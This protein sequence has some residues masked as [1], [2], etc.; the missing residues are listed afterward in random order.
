MKASILFFFLVLF[1]FACAQ[2]HPRI[3]VT[4][5]AELPQWE[6]GVLTIRDK[7]GKLYTAIVKNGK[8]SITISRAFSEE[9]SVDL[10]TRSRARFARIFLEP[11]TIHISDSGFKLHLSGTPLNERSQQLEETWDSLAKAQGLKSV[12]QVASFKHMK[13]GELVQSE[14]DDE[15]AVW[16]LYRYFYRNT[17]ASD[18]LYYRLFHTLTDRLRN[19]WPGIRM[20]AEVTGRYGAAI[21][22]PATL[23]EIADADKNKHPLYTEGHYYLIHFWASWCV[24]C[25]AENERLKTM[26]ASFHDR[27]RFVGVSLD[28]DRNKWINAVK[29]EGL[30]WLQLSDLRGW[31]A[32]VVRSYNIQSIPSNFLVDPKGIIIAKNVTIN[33]VMRQLSAAFPVMKDSQ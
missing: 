7:A 29:R 4:I 14:P 25:I 21:G 31:N 2:E 27:I 19:S 10:K 3:N 22:R 18:T 8:A 1:Q 17:E 33:E 30:S 24:P 26:Y 12:T 15:M 9:A 6:E 28:N 20:G 11:G 23:F 32:A 16:M 13:V 5:D